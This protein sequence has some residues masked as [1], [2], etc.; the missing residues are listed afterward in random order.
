M[1]YENLGLL[2]KEVNA[3]LEVIGFFDLDVKDVVSQQSGVIRT[4]CIDNLD[5]TNV[6]QTMF[7]RHVLTAQLRKVGIFSKDDRVETSKTLDQI[8]KHSKKE[9]GIHRGTLFSQSLSQCGRTTRTRSLCS[10]RAQAR[11]RT[12]S[13]VPERETSGARSTTASTR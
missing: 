8:F 5:R 2:L 11:S 4:N 6:V 10:T 13:L 7:A 3:E 1:K 12:T 9:N